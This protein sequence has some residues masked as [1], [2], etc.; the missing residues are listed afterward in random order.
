M[1]HSTVLHLFGWDKKFFL[2]FRAFIH[3]H[4]SGGRHQ[5]IVFGDVNED[6]VPASPDTSVMPSIFKNIIAM[7]KSMNN[8]EK[9]ILHGLFNNHIFYLL[10][11]QPW[12]LKKCCWVIW[13]GDLYI[14][15]VQTKDWRW[16]KN[17]FFR[18][19]IIKRIRHFIT[20]IKGDYELAKKWYGARGKY[21]HCLMYPSNLYNDLILPPKQGEVTNIL[22]GNSAD[23]TNNHAEVFQKLIAYNQENIQIV[24][25][26]SYGPADNAE[27]IVKHGRELFGDRFT[28][29]L[30]FMPFDKYLE[31]LGQIDIAVFAHKRQQAMGNIINLLGLGKKVYMRSDI[32]PWV[33]INELD[34]K[35]F[36]VRNF[37][38]TPINYAVSKYNRIRI[39]RHFSEVA[40]VKQLREIF[41]D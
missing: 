18:H 41:E 10:V 31:L 36:D 11:M 19:F 2:P 17:E 6:D 20:Y 13:G 32:T 34:V 12:L 14:H 21:H 22:V 38:L 28:P 1:S 29:L 3:E 39:K 40:L 33:T 16:K 27:R 15:N 7:T 24:C 4:F 25:P 5:F 23:P 35:V 9:I 26:L 30:D 8:A 37:D